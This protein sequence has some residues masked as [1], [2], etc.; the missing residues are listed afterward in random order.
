MKQYLRCLALLFA[1]AFTL[2]TVA[3]SLR[4]QTYTE[5][6]LY[7]FCFSGG[8]DCPDGANPTSG[9]LQA[10][11]GNFYGTTTY[12]GTSFAGTGAGTAFA[13]S[14]SGSLG[15]VYSF[16]SV[17][18]SDCTDGNQPQAMLVQGA[19]GNLYGTTQ[20]GETPGDGIAFKLTTSGAL[21]PLATFG[22][23]TSAGQNPES[24]LL[25]G[26]DGNFYGTTQ[27]G[28]ANGNGE[29]YKM[30]PSG[31]VTTLYSFGTTGTDGQGPY[32][33]LVQG[34]D[35]NFYGTT[36]GGGANLGGTMFR[37][38]SS[39]AFKTLYQFCSKS[40]CT[41]GSYPN[42]TLVQG[43]DGNFYGTTVNGGT[44]GLSNSGTAF[45]LTPA[46]TLTTLH[47]FCTQSHCTDGESPQPG[48]LLASDG[49]L[50]GTTELGG[51]NGTPD[52]TVFRIT[53]A[54]AFTLLYS[55]CGLTNC[56]DG[57][58]PYA[59]LAQGSDGNLYGT[60]FYGGNNVNGTA[61]KM[62][63]SP[64]LAAP[65]Q[66]SL[67]SSSVAAG[68]PVAL[69]WKVLNSFS[70]TFQQCYA[71][72]QNSASGAGEWTGKQAGTYSA[73]TKLYTGS[74]SITPTAS[75]TYTYELTC[76]GQESGFVTLTVTGATKGTSATTITATPNPVAVGETVALKGIV[77][78]SGA[79][80]TGTVKFS[81]GT[82]LLA[83]EN[84]SGGTATLSASTNGY[85][86]GAYPV[87]ATYSGD[88]NY[89]ASTSATYTVTLSKAATKTTL[90]ASPNPVTRP[91]ACTLKATV[92]R[93]AGSGFATGAVTF[94][95][96]TTTIGSAKLNGS[97]V[98]ILTASTASVG[99]GSYPIVATY[100]G[101]SSDGGSS[102]TVTVVVK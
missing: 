78:G 80:P 84:L 33:G 1:V 75:G 6:V 99:S 53:P 29:V 48:L 100:G 27:Y 3:P 30:T 89:N 36:T 56:T 45:K 79:T 65:V 12:G 22:G 102:S 47:N 87:V 101:D 93:A 72:V 37:I 34:T 2:L 14:A 77:T 4:A 51:S 95:V 9:L 63:V 43:S 15:T 42:G 20:Y 60:T 52:G 82:T 76:G 46:G 18:G 90:N 21:T 73:T 11:D 98:A 97:G 49:N 92:A 94:S 8:A 86:P 68:S 41:D 25:M 67:S 74:A 40:S 26:T 85:T 28:G 24:S 54:G 10:A 16:C 23:S 59:G 70:D 55:F 44:A 81:V 39:G 62:T 35:G 50:Y 88:A 38:S 5:S 91:A 13:L 96:A 31:T 17:G 69:S 57:Q 58:Q 32:A 19:D 7:S 66:L 71:F 83:R 61:Y 64:A